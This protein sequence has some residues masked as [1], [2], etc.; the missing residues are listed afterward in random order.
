MNSKFVKEEA[1]EV[2]G[3]TAYSK[4]SFFDNISYDGKDRVEMD[5]YV[6]FYYRA[7][8]RVRITADKNLN[9]D[10]FGQTGANLGNSRRGRGGRGR[11]GNGG[12]NRGRGGR[13]G[14]STSDLVNLATDLVMY[15]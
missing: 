5:K 4:S 2:T 14:A 3:S 8:R 15:L 9:M 10:T 1:R 7:D 12:A 13:G 6:C 11:G